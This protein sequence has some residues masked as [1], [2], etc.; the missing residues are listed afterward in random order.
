MALEDKGYDPFTNALVAKSMKNILILGG[1]GAMGKHLVQLL[2]ERGDK[3]TVTTRA[4]RESS[5][6]IE[7]IQGNAR[8]DRFIE[9]LLER[10]WDAIVDF[11]VYSTSFFRQRVPK[12]LEATGQYVFL[13]S[14]R[15][16]ADSTTPIQE[17]SPR[18]LDSSN[19]LEFLN[20]DEYSLAKARQEDLL[21]QSGKKNWTII[22]PYITYSEQRLQLGILEKEAWLYR[23]LQGRTIVF[24]EDIIDKLTT[25]TYGL[26]VASAIAAL[27]GEPRILGEAYHITQNDSVS[28]RQVLDLY[29]KV[30]EKH[31]GRKPKVA[32]LD[33]KRFSRCK[34]A[35]YQ[36]K[37]DRMFNRTFDN[38]KIAQFVNVNAFHSLEQRLERC[39]EEFLENPEFL[40]IDWRSEAIM[41]RYCCEVASLLE[42][43]HWKQRIKYLLYRFFRI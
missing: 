24:S 28:W 6:Y 41:D 31:H 38:S 18:L 11:M 35:V 39:L 12:L 5:A 21:K 26:D 19:N 29:L 43:G 17:D 25:L 7:Y 42:I 20:T 1:T 3:V 36:I 40:A 2:A 14:A 10:Q 15:I 9:P 22:R 4:R 34:K 32:L 8:E 33:M 16:Y 37:Y 13:S 23:A 30:L 27:I